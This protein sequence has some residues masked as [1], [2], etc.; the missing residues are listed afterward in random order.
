M[1]KNLS[2]F[3]IYI[4]L[5]A[6]VCAHLSGNSRHNNSPN[7][8][9]NIYGLIWIIQKNATLNAALIEAVDMM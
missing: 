5:L 1:I 6:M 9:R 8:H 7:S 4:T 2:T 3:M